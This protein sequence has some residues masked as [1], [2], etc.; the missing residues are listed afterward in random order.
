MFDRVL[1]NRLYSS[2]FKLTQYSL[3]VYD[4][5]FTVLYAIQYGGWPLSLRYGPVYWSLCGTFLNWMLTHLTKFQGYGD[6][7]ISLN[8]SNPIPAK[9]Y[10]Y[11][12]LLTPSSGSLSTFRTFDGFNFK[13][14]ISTLVSILLSLPE[15]RLHFTIKCVLPPTIYVYMGKLLRWFFQLLL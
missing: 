7:L 9:L 13:H 10:S 2:S 14:H 6:E 11:T 1:D 8:T 5:R 12:I 4:I 3:L 15:A